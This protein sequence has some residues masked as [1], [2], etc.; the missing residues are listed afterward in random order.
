MEE[1]RSS[2]EY[3]MGKWKFTAKEQGRGQGIKNHYEKIGV[4][5]ESG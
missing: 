4:R 5:G 1:I 2:F 3:S